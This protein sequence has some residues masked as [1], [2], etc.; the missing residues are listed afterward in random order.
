[1]AM[2]WPW[3]PH[4]FASIQ[5]TCDCDCNPD[6]TSITATSITASTR[7]LSFI[8]ATFNDNFIM[9]TTYHDYL[10]ILKG[11]R[12]GFVYGVKVR[13]PHALVMSILF[14]RGRFVLLILFPLNPSN[15]FHQLF[16]HISLLAGCLF[17]LER[18]CQSYFQGDQA[19][20][21]QSRQICNTIQSFPVDSEEGK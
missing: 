15:W 2:N 10:A 8:M 4:K 6:A 3:G 19:A 20:C 9:N 7:P 21:L 5:L 16:V 14:G 11:A 17:Q 18:P 13:F 1:M 12:N